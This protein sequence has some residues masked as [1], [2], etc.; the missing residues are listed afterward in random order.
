MAIHSFGKGRNDENRA[1]IS[2][3]SAV[4]SP[5]DC[6]EVVTDVENYYFRHCMTI[7][8]GIFEFE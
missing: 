6:P 4:F 5:Y 8:E 3:L 1:L 7:V 2:F